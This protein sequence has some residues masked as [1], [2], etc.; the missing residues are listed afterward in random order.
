MKIRL[1]DSTVL[2]FL[3][4]FLL[5]LSACG[6]KSGPFEPNILLIVL[7]GARA[8]RLSCYGYPRE[9]T[10]RI[11][12]IAENGAVFLDHFTNATTTHTSLPVIFFSSYR[13]ASLFSTGGVALEW[14]TRLLTPESVFTDRPPELILLPEILSARGWETAIFHNVPW[15]PKV[16]CLTRHF[17]HI[18]DF[19]SPTRSA[20]YDQP[21]ASALAQWL[22]SRRERP[23]FVYYHVMSPHPPFPPKKEDVEFLGEETDAALVDRVRRRPMAGRSKGWELEELKVLQD[24]YAGNLKHSDRWVGYIYDRLAALGLA[25]KTVIV[26]TSDHGEALGDGGYLA[27]GSDRDSVTRVPLIIAYPPGIKPGTRIGGFTES[28][29]ILPT[30][31]DLAGIE[32]P[33]D[34]IIDGISLIPVIENRR[35]AKSKVMIFGIVVRD[36]R[37]KL[38]LAD[39]E[40]EIDQLFDL[41]TDPDE[42]VNIICQEPGITQRL[43]EHRDRLFAEPLTPARRSRPPEFPFFFVVNEFRLAP[44]TVILTTE[45]PEI[46]PSGTDQA[47]E[48]PWLFIRD[49]RPAVAALVRR[50][51]GSSP[52]VILRSPLPDGAY[53][54][55]LLLETGVD[56]SLDPADLGF[57][58]RFSPGRSFAPPE[59]VEFFGNAGGGQSRY[60]VNLGR[61]VVK[62]ESFFLE[63][64][65]P[66][67]PPGAFRFRHV[68]FVP[69]TVADGS[70]HLFTGDLRESLKLMGYLKE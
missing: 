25:E 60:Y 28:V 33:E 16:N 19:P 37:Y 68:R 23:F 15:V 6:R 20:A 1:P 27:H 63:V 47:E 35:Q 48:K 32:L 39:D 7:D 22:S 46:P 10:P 61:A 66:D 50:P 36:Q 14:G 52:P 44:E 67:P 21:M 70:I 5:P 53:S 59:T 18:F 2:F 58:I 55:F 12:R 49:H 9:T 62:E 31:L 54:V 56:V 65:F 34:K 40:G 45:S 29:D 57:A 3:F 42:E 38:R 51:A 30:I 41:W 69:E 8:D 17:D 11:D 4:L 64:A 13:P 24:L 43:K 26:I